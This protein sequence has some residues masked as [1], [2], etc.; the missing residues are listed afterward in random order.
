MCHQESGLQ[1]SS[2][3]VSM[4]LNL[5]A[6]EVCK[7]A[8]KLLFLRTTQAKEMMMLC[9]TFFFFFF[10]VVQACHP[11]DQMVVFHVEWPWVIL[12]IFESQSATLTD[13][14]CLPNPNHAR[15]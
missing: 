5:L 1:I 2:I 10:A 12:E 3:S 6:F 8:K 14:C 11:P 15:S 7:F 4:S 13:L 9:R